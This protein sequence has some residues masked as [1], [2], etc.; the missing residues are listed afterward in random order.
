MKRWIS[1]SVKSADYYS[2]Q[3]L[4]EREIGDLRIALSISQD[5]YWYGSYGDTKYVSGERD[6]SSGDYLYHRKSE[7]V[8]KYG[9]SY[10]RDSRGRICAEPEERSRTRECEYIRVRYALSGKDAIHDAQYLEKIENGDYYALCCQVLIEFMGKEVGTSSLCGVIVERT[11]DD[12]I[13]EVLQDC[14]RE[15]MSE[16]RIVVGAAHRLAIKVGAC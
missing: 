2:D 4:G 13:A 8:K 7:S 1:Q 14:F 9:A 12:Y 10:W 16:A 15:A 6:C 5:L 11:T 3:V